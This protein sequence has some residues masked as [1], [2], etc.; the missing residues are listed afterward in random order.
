MDNLA[1]I[2]VGSTFPA[3]GIA[4]ARDGEFARSIRNSTERGGRGCGFPFTVLEVVEDVEGGL[5]REREGDVLADAVICLGFQGDDGGWVRDSDADGG[6]VV[7]NCSGAA[8][9]IFNGTK[10]DAVGPQI[11]SAAGK[12][13][14]E[15]V[16]R[17]VFEA[18][19]L[20]AD[21]AV[22]GQPNFE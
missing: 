17:D 14:G 15:G 4:D 8:T 22:V 13:P 1:D 6:R 2:L 21:T 9:A 19:N 18:E 3:G 10:A 11:K 16:R 5:A 7:V 20:R 12:G